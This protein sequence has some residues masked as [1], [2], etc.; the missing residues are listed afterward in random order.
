M[1]IAKFI[2]RHYQIED[3]YGEVELAVSQLVEETISDDVE[4]RQQA[5]MRLLL[6]IKEQE[7]ENYTLFL[8]DKALVYAFQHIPQHDRA[9]KS[10]LN[11]LTGKGKKPRRK[12]QARAKAQ[13]SNS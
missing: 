10:Y 2:N 4:Y 5:L 11:E 9:I 13:G 8:L 1:S 7:E 3:L 12:K 6:I